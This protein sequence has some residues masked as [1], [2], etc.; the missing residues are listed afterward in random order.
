MQD[1]R[2]ESGSEADV[3]EVSSA[4]HVDR[5]VAQHGARDSRHGGH[6]SIRPSVRSRAYL[7][8]HASDFRAGF[9]SRVRAVV[10]CTLDEIIA[11]LDDD[12][13]DVAEMIVEQRSA[14]RS[15][16]LHMMSFVKPEVHRVS[17]RHQKT[18]DPR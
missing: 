18:T 3:R 12:D 1:V 16:Q 15:I 14:S 4:G 13:E 5:V 9:F 17:Q 6:V 7:R 11:A 2:D 10:M 8:N